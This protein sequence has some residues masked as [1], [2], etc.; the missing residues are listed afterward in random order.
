MVIDRH[1]IR[2]EILN[3]SNHFEFKNDTHAQTISLINEEETFECENLST[4]TTMKKRKRNGNNIGSNSISSGIFCAFDINNSTSFGHFIVWYCIWH[5]SAKQIIQRCLFFLLRLQLL[6]IFFY[7]IRSKSTTWYLHCTHFGF[8]SSFTVPVLL[9]MRLLLYI[10]FSFIHSH[11][12]NEIFSCMR[13]FLVGIFFLVAFFSI[14]NCKLWKLN[15]RVE[16]CDRIKSFE[17]QIFIIADCLSLSLS[18]MFISILPFIPI[19]IY[20]Y[21]FISHF[22]SL[23][24]NE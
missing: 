9:L 2:A 13:S 22:K 7:H 17:L 4:A 24:S 1:R 15:N 19:P 14:P 16:S 8:V 6:Q 21:A 18:C 12:L 11:D 5:Q 23:R 10:F 3:I 20:A